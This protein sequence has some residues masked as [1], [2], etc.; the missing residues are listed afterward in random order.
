M[1]V[2]IILRENLVSFFLKR[3]LL[4]AA[5]GRL[6]TDFHDIRIFHFK[7]LSYS[8]NNS[9]ELFFSNKYKLWERLASIVGLENLTVFEFGVFKGAGMRWWLKRKLNLS[10][11]GFDTF[12]GLPDPWVRNGEIYFERKHFSTKGKLPKGWEATKVKLYKGNVF[13]KENEI[14]IELS[15]S[16]HGKRIFIFDFDL[17]DPTKFVLDII[18][19]SWISGDILFFDEGFDSSGEM[20]L[21]DELLQKN[22]NWKVVGWTNLACAI[23][24][25]PLA[26]KSVGKS[27]LR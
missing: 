16:T 1:K 23:I 2:P 8:T 15:K 17:L 25:S 10:Y 11:V 9:F 26:L 20:Q 24:F 3:F 22:G 14:S 19:K 4:S 12:E 13:D 18:K 27:A 5:A 7:M 6:L 21:L